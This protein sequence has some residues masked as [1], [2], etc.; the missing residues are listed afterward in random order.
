ML[1]WD[2]AEHLANDEWWSNGITATAPGY[3]IEWEADSLIAGVD[4]TIINGGDGSDTLF[5]SAGLDIFL[6]ESGDVGTDT[7]NNFTTIQR[8]QIDIS[9]LLTGYNYTTS[10]INDFV[11][12]TEASGNT[13]IAVDGNG[14]AGGPS[15]TNVVI[16]NWCHRTGFV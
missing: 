10:D 7:I 9:D 11:T 8:D 14:T 13:T 15:F 4:H 2:Y 12:L 16:L 3:V 5:G 1:L 6:F